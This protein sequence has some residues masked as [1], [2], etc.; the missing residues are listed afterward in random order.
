M[1]PQKFEDNYGEKNH[2]YI[3]E[4]KKNY[5]HAVINGGQRHKIMGKRL[6]AWLE[7]IN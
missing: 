4:S 2:G 1:K 3:R 6:L 7:W 5:F